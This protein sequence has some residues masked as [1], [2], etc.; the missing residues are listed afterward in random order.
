M[1]K[2][3]QTLNE[4]L[5]I[6]PDYNRHGENICHIIYKDQARQTLKMKA[7]ELL[8]KG[9]QQLNLDLHSRRLW[10]NKLLNKRNLNP[11]VINSSISLI[12]IKIRE[13][14]GNKDGCYAYITYEAIKSFNDDRLILEG[15]TQI[16]YLSSKKTLKNKFRDAEYLK[17]TYEKQLI[18]E[19]EA[20]MADDRKFAEP[21]DETKETFNY[22]KK[23]F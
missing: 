8:R 6:K 20:Y 21:K 2:E 12:P 9:F 13:A 1:N 4:I 15:G 5:G 10:A 14:I 23:S 11:I 7:S 3:L 19:Y 22:L 18:A 16:N 17:A